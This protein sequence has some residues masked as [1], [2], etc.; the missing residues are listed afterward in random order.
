MFAGLVRAVDSTDPMA[1]AS[2]ATSAT[3]CAEQCDAA[4]CE[5]WT[6]CPDTET[7][8]WGCRVMH[9]WGVYG[10]LALCT[11]CQC[12]A[13]VHWLPRLCD[14]CVGV[15]NICLFGFPSPQPPTHPDPQR[16]PRLALCR[17]AHPNIFGEDD[18]EDVVLP[19]TTC[20]LSAD[21]VEGRAAK[22]MVFGNGLPWVGGWRVSGTRPGAP[23][24]LLCVLDARL[25]L[26]RRGVRVIS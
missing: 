16:P 21:L 17:C 9:G 22:I 12:C 26:Q 4:A 23:T 3:D 10:S 15:A 20:M 8:G 25:T 24:H 2:T 18:L 6:W 19:P 7:D 14:V 5:N 11:G 1:P 13:I